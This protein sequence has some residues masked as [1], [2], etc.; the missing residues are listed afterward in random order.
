MGSRG[1]TRGPTFVVHRLR[2]HRSTLLRRFRVGSYFSDVGLDA[3]TDAPADE[4]HPPISR[5]PQRVNGEP[6]D[7]GDLHTYPELEATWLPELNQGR[8]PGDYTKGSAVEVIWWCENGGHPFK[9]RVEARTRGCDS[10]YCAGRRILEG[11]NDFATAHPELAGDWHPWKNRKYP[12]EVM[13]GS[14]RKF[15]WRCRDGH[16]RPQSIPNR[17]KS[18]GCVECAW[19]ERPGNR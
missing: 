2:P 1:L 14:I 9:M 7:R 18:G 10:P 5:I 12:N 13:A 19:H 17:I 8:D 16:E 3:V 11:F 15:E 6:D 4:E